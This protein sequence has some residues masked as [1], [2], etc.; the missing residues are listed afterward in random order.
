MSHPATL[1]VPQLA[2]SLRQLLVWADKAEAYAATRG[3]DAN[4]LLGTRLSPDMFPL[5]RQV[6]SA[7]D[8]AKLCVS[9]LTAT[10]AP[11]HA[12]DQKTWE[13]VRVRVHD[14]VSW[15]ESHRDETYPTASDV[16]V[17]FGWYPGH[18]L[19]GDTYLLQFAVPNFYFHL[20]MVYALLRHGGVPLGKAD[21][22]GPIG[23]IADPA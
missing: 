21:F 20:S 22:L 19:P 15:I 13:D 12:D 17:R 5:V 16:L 18:A 1:L 14:V 2:F 8:T 11:V 23:F 4:V 7:C 9:R 3:F 10:Q 6:G